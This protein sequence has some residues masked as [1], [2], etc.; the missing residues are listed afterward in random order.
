MSIVLLQRGD[1]AA[2]RMVDQ[3]NQQTSTRINVVLCSERIPT[4][5]GYYRTNIGIVF[6]QRIPYGLGLKADLYWQFGQTP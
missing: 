4:K 5:E 2:C 1:I 6:L 3:Q